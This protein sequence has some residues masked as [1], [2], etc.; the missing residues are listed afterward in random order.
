MIRHASA[1]VNTNVNAILPLTIEVKNLPVFVVTVSHNAPARSCFCYANKRFNNRC[2]M[3][4]DRDMRV[5]ADSRTRSHDGFHQLWRPRFLGAFSPFEVGFI[6]N[7]QFRLSA[8]ALCA[9]ALAACNGLGSSMS[10]PVQR[11][12]QSST[13]AV[14][15]DLS[16]AYAMRTRFAPAPNVTSDS[17]VTYGGGPVLRKPVVFVVFWGFSGHSADPSGEESYLTH[18]LNGVGGS[19]WMNIT[20]QYYQIKDGKHQFIKNLPG[21]LA[22]KWVDLTDP[23]PS[24]PSDAQIKAE[25]RNLEAHFGF[26]NN[27]SYIV[28]TSHEHNSSGFGSNYCAYHGTTSSAGGT[29]SYTNLPYMT[30]AGANCGENF[31]NSGPAGLLDGVSIVEGHEYAGSQTDP[32]P[33]SGWT[34]EIGDLCAWQKPP[35][36]DI[37][38]STGVFAVQGLFSNASS[39]CVIKYP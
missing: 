17:V 16:Q 13:V 35:A 33:F 36:G 29:I 10:E 31:I 7:H 34:P 20:H 15:H 26:N 22:G 18:F 30:D 21:Q 19:S 9:S 12:Q 32:Q 3:S 39:S 38:L 1:A 5:R 6:M 37:K 11:A 24:T 23:E 2:P 28:A 8:V 14:S 25:A 4:A 27:A